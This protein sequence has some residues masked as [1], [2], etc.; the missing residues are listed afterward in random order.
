[1]AEIA[2]QHVHCP[3]LLDRSTI[4]DGQA[5]PPMNTSSYR[6]HCKTQSLTLQS[7][8]SP[9]MEILHVHVPRRDHLTARLNSL[10]GQTTKILL[11]YSGLRFILGFRDHECHCWSFVWMT[12]RY[13]LVSWI[14]CREWRD[15]S[16]PN[17]RKFLLLD[18]PLVFQYLC[19]AQQTPH[20]LTVFPLPPPS[21]PKRHPHHP[22]K[23][24]PDR[25]QT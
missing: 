9:A 3:V 18:H 12:V 14:A 24:N 7:R 19:Q 11:L 17:T 6:H 2:P 16:G 8:F 23:Q 10:P 1:M 21:N 20:I 25:Q 22:H 15:E 13:A 4:K 5:I